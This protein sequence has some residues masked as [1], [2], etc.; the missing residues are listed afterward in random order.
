MPIALGIIAALVAL[1]GL[2]LTAGGTWL[3]MLG[4]SLYYIL[5]GVGFLITAALLFLRRAAGLWI[6]AL[7]VVGTLVWA[8]AEA[9]LQWWPMA[10]RG[11]VV[12]LLGVVLLLP[13]ISGRLPRSALGRGVLAASLL[14][15]VIVGVVAMFTS[16]DPMEATGTLPF[17]RVTAA[18]G[19]PSRSGD[20]SAYGGTSAG[21]RYS[22]LTDVTPSNVS[23]LKVAWTFHTGDIKRPGDPIETTYELT[24]IKVGDKLFICTPH[25]I[26]M[27]LD[28]DSG[29]ALWRFD[30]H[31][32]K[33]KNLQHLTCRGVSYHA[34]ADA[35]GACAKRIYLPTADARLFALDADTGKPCPDF[36]EGGAVN[37]WQGMPDPA[38][39][40]GEYYSTSPPVVTREL[41]IIAG[42]VT[43]NYSTD[44]PSGVVRAYDA[45]TGRLVWNFDSGNPDA[46]EPIAPDQHYV[47]NSPNSWSIA[48]AD[49]Q[50]GLLYVPYG[51]QTPDQWGA[52]RGANTER[53]ASSITAL[54][55]ATG[56][57]R[58]VY[59]T[60]HH[61]LWDMDVGAQP[62]LLDLQ[63]PD[64]L[65]PALVAPTKT[66]NLF[67]LDRRTGAPIFPAPEK[68]VPQDA[69][70]GD[71]TAPT[72]PFSSVTLMPTAP[73]RE[74]DMWGVLLF[75]QLACRIAFRR[76]RY[77][78]PFTPPST[79]GSLVFPG[80][81]GV[82]DWGGIAVDPVR[83][84]AFANPSYMA[85]VDVL[86]ARDKARPKPGQR[87]SSEQGSN[88]NYGAPYSADLH[89]FLSFLGLPCQAPPWGYVAGL[90]L[91]TGRLVYRRKNGTIQDQ[92]PLPVPLAMGVPSLGGPIVTASGVAFLTSTLDYYVRAY[93]VADGR[94][95]WQDRLPAGGQATPMTYRSDKTHRQYVVVVAGGHGSLGTKAGDSIIA[96]TLP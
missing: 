34:A 5:A 61:D 14:A 22:P 11:G 96:Y 90:D 66:G 32:R 71:H 1:L 4:G 10:A 80:N 68:P 85:F 9:G 40:V 31:I 8:V 73:L 55:I 47:K 13:W 63:T 45:T 33:A 72:Q 39:H 92:S 76:L 2:A 87:P 54:D 48:S 74:Q 15:S 28:P 42:E 94:M 78:G 30:P 46:T 70:S 84:I 69:A 53:F 27:A 89:P 23:T 35:S 16:A 17:E 44:E 62:S 95:L 79:R 58:W 77:D 91:R 86:V 38:R 56:K 26:A 64:G 24:P 19:D 50:L 60:V 6:Y 29:R 59:Q 37:L 81:F 67:V 41:V 88:P 7:V 51:N 75:D 82:I 57:V 25:D 36:G 52:G 20:W 83:Q 43:D 12:F 18:A 21:Q 49:E 93:D 65:V 3:A